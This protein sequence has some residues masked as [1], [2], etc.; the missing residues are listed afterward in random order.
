MKFELKKMVRNPIAIIAV[1]AVLFLNLY[2]LLFGS[3]SWD[4]FYCARESPFQTD[5]K[6][7]QEDGAYFAG[8]INDEWT[9]KYSAEVDALLRDPKN[10]VLE[11]EK[12]QIRKEYSEQEIAERPWLFSKEEFIFSHEYQKYEPM[13]FSAHF[14][15]FAER[16]GNTHAENYRTQYP[17]K[18]GEV[19]AAKS[20]ELHGFMANEYIA[21]HNYDW[22]WWKIRNVHSNLPFTVGLIMLIVLSPIFA[23]E[24]SGKTDALLLTS[25]H[26]KNKLI[27]AK[28]KSGFL[29]ASV[30][31][32]V[33]EITN[34][35][36][37]FALYGTTGAEAYWQNW[38]L[39]NAPF[40]WNQLQIT[41]VTIATSFLGVLFTA[42]LIMLISSLVK[43]QFTALIIGGVLLVLPMLS[44]AFSGSVLFQR[45]YNFFP[46][47]VLSGILIWQK[48]DLTYLF[49]KAVHTQYI[50]IT[51][52]AITVILGAF[53]SYFRFKNHQVEN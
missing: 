1:I 30:F 29:F 44:F 38:M 2:S 12:E 26:G 9:A 13:Q 42:A 32:A 36:L 37:I 17:G 53:I 11:T 25:K 22:G 34:T 19:L 39:D 15:E 24:Y 21:H 20:E 6:R 35:F 46:S 41:L 4:T 10:H 45:I 27:S 31:W 47:R 50:I 3:Q 51:F 7:L 14:Y 49:G 8:E 43:N 23:S 5:I 48:F 33:I 52:A 28:L 40:P 18:K 16:F